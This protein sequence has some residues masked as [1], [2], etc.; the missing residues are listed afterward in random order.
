MLPSRARSL[1]ASHSWCE[2]GSDELDAWKEGAGSLCVPLLQYP[3]FWCESR[4]MGWT[5]CFLL[6][7]IALVGRCGVRARAMA[8][9]G[10]TF[11]TGGPGAI[12]DAEE[13]EPQF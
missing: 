6:E 8:W 10:S 9:E 11:R 4:R 7:L 12:K 3:L 1:E 2:A 13:F 5:K